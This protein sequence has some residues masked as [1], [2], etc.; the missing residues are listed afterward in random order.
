[1]AGYG[2]ACMDGLVR[3]SIAAWKGVPWA[4]KASK[5]GGEENIKIAQVDSND[6][7]LCNE[8]ANVRHENGD[9]GELKAKL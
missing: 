3:G 2:A 9:I 4:I 6:G 8:E 1:M 5:G 7:K